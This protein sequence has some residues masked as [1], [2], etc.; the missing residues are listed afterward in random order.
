MSNSPLIYVIGDI[1]VDRMV[2]YRDHR[3]TMDGVPVVM[4]RKSASRPADWRTGLGGAGAVALMA[5]ALGARVIL[6]GAGD[7]ACQ[8]LIL[9]DQFNPDGDLMRWS[10]VGDASRRCGRKT[11]HIVDGMTLLRV[12]DERPWPISAHDYQAMVAAMSSAGQPDA[13]ILSDYAKGVLHE[14]SIR[15]IRAAF[16]GVPTFVDPSAEKL[17]WEVYGGQLAA[18]CPNRHELSTRPHPHAWIEAGAEVMIEKQDEDGLVLW[19]EQRTPGE[20][21]REAVWMP[22]TVSKTASHWEDRVVDT[23]GAGDMMIAAL[24]VERCRGK[25]WKDACDFANAAAGEKCRHWGAVAV[26]REAVERRMRLCP[27]V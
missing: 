11:R 21:N 13:L 10:F 16:P 24:A 25:S 4:S 14:E 23:V 17:D 6:G 8:K 22:S 20:I 27:V 5:S 12:D 19:I 3:K 1:F 9:R 18:I 7:D 2:V 15:S 26:H